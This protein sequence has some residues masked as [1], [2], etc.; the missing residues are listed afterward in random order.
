[1]KNLIEFTHFE[2]NSYLF[3]NDEQKNVIYW[4]NYMYF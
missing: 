4:G 2:K 3:N 1:M